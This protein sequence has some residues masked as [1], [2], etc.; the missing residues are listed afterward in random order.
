MHMNGPNENLHRYTTQF[1]TWELD[2]I[3]S[4]A[5]NESIQGCDKKLQNFPPDPFV[6]FRHFAE[7]QLFPN[8]VI[9]FDNLLIF[10]K[11]NAFKVVRSKINAK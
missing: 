4:I 6:P 9:Y 2:T 5:K 3:G 10:Y 1:W 7:C 11:A 8:I